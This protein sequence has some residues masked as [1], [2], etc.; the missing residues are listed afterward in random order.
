MNDSPD[1]SLTRRNLLK[2][3]GLGVGAVWVSTLPLSGCGRLP[4][5][6]KQTTGNSADAG[7]NAFYFVQ[8]SDPHWGFTGDAVNPEPTKPLPMVVEMINALPIQPDFVA[9]TGDLTHT[10][11]DAAARKAR[12]TEFQGIIKGIKVPVKLMP[13]EHDAGE[14]SG[15]VYKSV[16]GDSY[17]TFNHK[18]VQFIT[19]DNVSDATGSVG[20]TQRTWLAQQLAT[21]SKDQPLIVLTHR[22]LF[23]LKP[24]WDWATKDGKQVMDLFMPFANVT[25]FFGHIHQEYHAMTGHIPH[26]SARSI[27]F[28]LP[29]PSATGPRNP[30][31]WD[32]AHP[33][34][35]LGFR[36]VRSDTGKVANIREIPLANA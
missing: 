19:L 17:Y 5:T 15:A 13:G 9:F 7:A 33:L 24:E 18:G 21:L 27:M 20:D 22:P 26:H 12:L 2:L 14:D 8:V 4:N 36:D 10:T 25:V 3:S 1:L 34:A 30:V 11:P 35:G 23:D 28:P 6:R 32:V 29:P 16:F 31:L